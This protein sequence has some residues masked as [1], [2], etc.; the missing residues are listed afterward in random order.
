MNPKYL[1]EVVPLQNDIFDNR[2]SHRVVVFWDG[3]RAGI[4]NI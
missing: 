1:R 3:C 2:A 4:N